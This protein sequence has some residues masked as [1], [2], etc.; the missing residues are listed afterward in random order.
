MRL[1]NLRWMLNVGRAGYWYQ[2]LSFAARLTFLNELR[3]IVEGGRI[4]YP[5]ALF[6]ITVDDV[7]R[8]ATAAM[9]I[10]PTF[11]R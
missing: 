10:K 4:A 6:H 3:P 2:R 9:K 5:D 11:D 1:K 7:I 8:A